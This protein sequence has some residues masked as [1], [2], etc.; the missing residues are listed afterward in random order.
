MIIGTK[1][2]AMEHFVFVHGYLNQFVM[3]RY[4]KSQIGKIGFYNHYTTNTVYHT[5]AT[6]KI[7]NKNSILSEERFLNWFVTYNVNTKSINRSI[8]SEIVPIFF[9]I[10]LLNFINLTTISKT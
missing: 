4:T 10:N 7:K 6:I 2:V 8:V 3:V 5:P 1:K 9:N